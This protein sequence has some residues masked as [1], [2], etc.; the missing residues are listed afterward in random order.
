VLAAESVA[1]VGAS[2]IPGSIGR[3]I[4]HNIVTGGH[5]GPVY[6]VNP[7]ASEL[8]GVPCVPSPAALPGPVDLAVISL[9][10][11]AVLAAAEECGKRGVRALVVITSGLDG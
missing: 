4:V 9:P 1:V 8:E 6:A 5:G 2:R 10:A 7:H 3:C 11:P